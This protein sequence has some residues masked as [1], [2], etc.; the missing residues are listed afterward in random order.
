MSICM[1]ASVLMGISFAEK[2]KP[3][4]AATAFGSN[5]FLKVNGT[6]I[7]NRSGNG[8]TIYLRGV[9]AGGLFVKEDWQNSTNAADQKTELETLINRFGESKAYE[10]LEYYK[11]NFWTTSDFD[12]CAEM[13]M[14]V[15]RVPFTYMNIYKKSGNNWVVRDD[16]FTRLDWFVS[17]CS[18]RGIYVILD[19]HGA[20]GSQNG[21]D[22]SGQ[23]IDNVNDV[24]FFSN[25]TYMTQT[26]DLW[27]LVAAHYR[28]NP[29]VAA[30]DTLNEPGEKAGS[31]GERHWNFY[32]RMYDAIRSVDPDHIII[33]ESC[34]GTG[35]LPNPSRYGWTNVAYEYHNYPWGNETDDKLDTLKSTCDNF[36]N[37]VNSANY[38]VPTYIGEFTVFEAW[39]G[40]QYW[41]EKYNQGH[42]RRTIWVLGVFITRTEQLKQILLA[43]Q[44][45]T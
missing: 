37:S 8:N 21:Q 32:N 34:W 10:L 9:N 20:F 30:Y 27:K 5:D 11:D 35:N 2:T 45:Q 24:T 17:E 41:L 44:S 39:S 42:I 38:G 28:G 1:V 26:L 13:G 18:K 7:K 6:Q 4:K 31:T 16:A 23:I 14:S 15:I 22:H 36:I 19:L 12:N 43:A 3:V 25:E 40:W 29:A 33:M